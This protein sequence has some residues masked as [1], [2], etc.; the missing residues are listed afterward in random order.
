[1]STYSECTFSRYTRW[2]DLRDALLSHDSP[3]YVW[4]GV[5]NANWCLESSLDRFAR[6]Y[7]KNDR[8][9]LSK[10]LLALYDSYLTEA[11]VDHE[12]D[13][14]KLW[15]LGQHFGL[16]TPL[17][18]WSHS[19]MVAAFFALTSEDS[20]NARHARD[21]CIWRLDCTAPFL[22]GGDV[23]IVSIGGGIW[24]IRLRAQ[25][26]LFTDLRR[27]ECLVTTLGRTSG[28]LDALTAYIFPADLIEEGQP[29][30]TSMMID[31][32]HLFPDHEGV[33]RHV[34]TLAGS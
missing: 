33:V 21:A 31:D 30:L 13:Q 16:P 28:H 27:G 11:A 10:N 22:S 29:E 24:N 7:Q 6:E 4:R 8:A 3:Q 19:P 15:A 1:L 25:Q 20:S 26:G 14:T 18:D 9:L 34:R 17:L 2:V 12:A 23:S 5:A 32:L